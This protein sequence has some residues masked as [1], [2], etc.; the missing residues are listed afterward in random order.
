MTGLEICM[1]ETITQAKLEADES[2][3]ELQSKLDQ[4]IERHK[5]LQRQ[6]KESDD[7]QQELQRKLEQQGQDLHNIVEEEML[8]NVAGETPDEDQREQMEKNEATHDQPLNPVVGK[9]GCA[10]DSQEGLH[11]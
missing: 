4:S 2:L 5:E 3:Q 1:E 7:R 10:S 6:L 9:W 11:T 8:E